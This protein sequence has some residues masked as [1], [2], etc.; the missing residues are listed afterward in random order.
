MHPILTI[1]HS[2]HEQAAFLARLQKDDIEALLDVRSAP[3]SR[4]VPWF[5]KEDI[6]QAARAAGF[7]Y[8]F[9]GDALGG[10]PSDPD[11]LDSQGKPN[12]EKLARRDRFQHGL[13]RLEE[14]RRQGRRIVLVCAEENPANCHRHLLIARQL[15]L[16]RQVPV[17]HLLKDG[18]RLRAL[19]LLTQRPAQLTLFP[20]G[21]RPG[22]QT[23]QFS[24]G[25][26]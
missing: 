1:G 10:K 24:R 4:H 3:Y 12:Y 9:M 16:E 8:L 11:L 23:D 17:I 19:E 20:K 13:D 7:M 25:E 2:N 22:K 14:G 26:G 18:S 15:E 6:E 21:D 5:N